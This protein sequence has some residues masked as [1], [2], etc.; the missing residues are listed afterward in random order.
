MMQPMNIDQGPERRALLAGPAGDIFREIIKAGVLPPDDPRL[1]HDHPDSPAMALLLDL[2]S[3]TC[4]IIP[5][6]Y[7]HPQPFGRTDTARLKSG[8]LVYCGVRRTP[9]CAVFGLT[10]AATFFL[11]ES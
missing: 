9:L 5:I 4:D 3:T 10:K 1:V 6:A 7:A 11:G 8:E 2:G